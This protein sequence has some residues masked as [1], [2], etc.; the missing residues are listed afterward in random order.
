MSVA[1]PS[2]DCL[3]TTSGIYHDFLR[4]FLGVSLDF[5]RTSS[6]LSQD[7]LRSLSFSEL[8]H[9]FLKLS[10]EFPRSFSWLLKDSS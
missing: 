9:N 1:G 4:A 2:Q 7:V 8:F 10:Q 5:L 3:K 6:C